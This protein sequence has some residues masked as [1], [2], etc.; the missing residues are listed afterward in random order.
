[1]KSYE[2]MKAEAKAHDPKF[3]DYADLVKR[4]DTLQAALEK[5]LGVKL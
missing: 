2:E 1:M 5:I 3:E 4:V